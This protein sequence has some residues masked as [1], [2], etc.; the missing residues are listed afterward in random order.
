[1]LD[2]IIKKIDEI[3]DD[4]AQNKI[5]KDIKS[6]FV[7][8]AQAVNEVKKDMIE[9]KDRVDF[10]FD[11]EQQKTKALEWAHFGLSAALLIFMVFTS[12]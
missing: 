5:V 10:L 12:V 2:P 1:M 4:I 3:V 8:A 11:K 6:E 9:M 7:E